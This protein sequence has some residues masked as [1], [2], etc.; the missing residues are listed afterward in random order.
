MNNNT[1]DEQ[2]K[3]KL[4][5]KQH[6]PHKQHKQ[7]EQHKQREQQEQ[8]EQHHMNTPPVVIMG[9]GVI[10]TCVAYYLVK[11][12][13]LSVTLID[14]CANAD[15]EPFLP[16]AASGHAGGF[17]ARHWSN[18][19]ATEQLTQLSYDLH[20]ELNEKILNNTEYRKIDTGEYLS[21]ESEHRVYGSTVIDISIPPPSLKP[22]ALSLSRISSILK[23]PIQVFF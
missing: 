19:M 10:G 14:P 9:G 16:P 18:G 20:V 8:Q 7:H 2:P 15:G 3:Q 1:E 11:N 5:H 12:H 21:E 13:N 23:Q 22:V 17:L 4:H 6:K